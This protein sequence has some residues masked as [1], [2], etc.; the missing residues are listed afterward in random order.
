MAA[1]PAWS[2]WWVW[3][4]RMHGLRSYRI[5]EVLGP[6]DP[7]LQS[8]YAFQAPDRMRLDIAT[9]AQ[10]IFIGPTR[11]TRAD[12]SSPWQAEQI[13]VSLAVPSFTWDPLTPGE[14]PVAV[15]IVG[16]ADVDGV[17]TQALAFFQSS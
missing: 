11:Y 15:R 17:S 6:A 9:G 4:D 14:R 2:T 8:D 1:L 7:P 10:T 12:P 3:Q 5:H 16:A 13:G